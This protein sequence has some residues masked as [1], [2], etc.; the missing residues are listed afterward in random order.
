MPLNGVSSETKQCEQDGSALALYSSKCPTWPT[1]LGTILVTCLYEV[2]RNSF[3]EDL[4]LQ[5][6]YPSGCNGGDWDWGL[7]RPE[8][9]QMP[10][11][12]KSSSMN[13]S[14]CTRMA[15]VQEAWWEMSLYCVLLQVISCLA[16]W[17]LYFFAFFKS[18]GI[19]PFSTD[20]LVT[21]SFSLLGLYL[22]KALW[23]FNHS[24]PKHSP[25][26]THCRLSWP[27]TGI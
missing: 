17:S 24:K 7:K 23:N 18:P 5:G 2:S 12:L 26:G 21:G 16:K 8:K 22:I 20:F 13:G 25:S 14:R 3:R 1:S 9:D 27:T 19:L 10:K 15:R 6:I 4:W 11:S